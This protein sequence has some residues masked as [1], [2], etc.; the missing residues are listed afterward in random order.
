[1][2]IEALRPTSNQK[3]TYYAT[4]HDGR[5]TQK[6]NLHAVA[7]QCTSTYSYLQPSSYF[8]IIMPC[9]PN[10]ATRDYYLTK[11]VQPIVTTCWAHCTTQR[12]HAWHYIPGSGIHGAERQVTSNVETTSCTCTNRRRRCRRQEPP[13]SYKIFYYSR[14]VRNVGF[15]G[16][17]F[18]N[19][20]QSKLNVTSQINRVVQTN[21]DWPN[22]NVVSK[23]HHCPP[24]K[25]QLR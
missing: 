21:F 8:H 12:I 9:N 11:Q 6:Y 7:Q 1:M 13:F 5:A 14:T 25:V 2:K 19:V 15:T 24:M 22:Q 4:V 10:Q 23:R 16:S 18:L 20:F 17:K 3:P